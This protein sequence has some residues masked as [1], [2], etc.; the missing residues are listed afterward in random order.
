[1]CRH[2]NFRTLLLNHDSICYLNIICIELNID[3]MKTEWLQVC[4]RLLQSFTRAILQIYM[5]D[6]GS[7]G[8][9][10]TALR[11]QKQFRIR[12]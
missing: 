3:R 12:R 11:K 2:Q 1:M 9:V 7:L 6:G 10:I 5:A 4:V 8:E